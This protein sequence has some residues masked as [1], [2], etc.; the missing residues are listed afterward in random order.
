M[1]WRKG[2]GWWCKGRT[3]VRGGDSMLALVF[4]VETAGAPVS[5]L[6]S[7]PRT[8][9]LRRARVIFSLRRGVV[10]LSVF[11]RYRGERLGR[12]SESAVDVV[13]GGVYSRACCCAIA[14]LLVSVVC[15]FG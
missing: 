8:L 13:E 7:A 2:E 4:R 1:A 3:G 6:M 14:F 11:S 12:V 15:G 5:P 9:D 10:V